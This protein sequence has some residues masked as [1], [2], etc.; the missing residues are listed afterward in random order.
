M[1][2]TGERIALESNA[3]NNAMYQQLRL[4]RWSSVRDAA[5]ELIEPLLDEHSHVALVGGGSCD[6]LPLGRLASRVQ[7][8]DLIDFDTSSTDRAVS[9]LPE[10]LRARVT[11]IEHDVTG[12]SADLVL[13]ALQQD[14]PLPESLPLPYGP[15]GSGE[16]DLVVGDMLYTQLLHAGLIALGIEGTRQLELMRRYDP[17]LV[18]ALVQRIEASVRS[19]GHAVHI[20]DLACWAS[21]HA[22]PRTL[23]E[24]FEDPDHRWRELRRHDNCDPHLML[25]KLGAS[26]VQHAWWRWPFEPNK[27][28]LVRATVSRCAIASSL[29]G[30]AI[31]RTP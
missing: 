29:G 20:H 11:V 12:G 4:E 10:P 16:Y 28:F 19:G 21:N 5:W 18:R 7:H 2:G 24:V 9:R 8:V 6:D 17:P 3:R 31:W 25:H 14:A 1:T 27:Q 13:R 15:L 23:D 22:Q 26:I 30:E